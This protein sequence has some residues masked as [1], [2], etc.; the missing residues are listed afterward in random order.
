MTR[1]AARLALLF[2]LLGLGSSGAASYIHYQLLTVPAYESVCDVSA[3]VNCTDVYSSRYG[4]FG[5]VSVAVLGA[6]WFGLA[7]LLSVAALRGGGKLRQSV[8]EYLFAGSTIG[9]A[10]VLYLG[11]ASFVV[12]K[13]VCPFC[14]I[15]YVAVAGLFLVSGRYSS[16]SLLAV[17]RQLATDLRQLVA[18]PAALGLAALFVAGSAGALVLFP[19]QPSEGLAGGRGDTGGRTAATSG[20]DSS[21]PDGFEEWFAQLPRVSLNE[22]LEG[23]DV[24]VV[25]FNDY[26]CPPCR[27]T[28]YS[29]Q[30]VFQNLN[31]RYPG[32]V[33]Y[34][35]RDFPL[36]MECNAIVTRD[37]HVSGCEA[38][39]AVRLARER[40]RASEMEAWL[41]ENQPSL[42]PELVARG[43]RD[44]GGAVD[45]QDRYEATLSDV[46]ADIQRGIDIGV[47]STPTFVINNVMLAGGVPPPVLELI[48]ERELERA[49]AGAP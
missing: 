3:T 15:T 21:V 35:T 46:R 2:A 1:T 38:A 16:M 37:F 36:D 41:F 11:Y 33:K 49:A 24:V 47:R 39:V 17:P 25:K 32:R 42:T 30:P 5:G 27:Q 8:T 43:A 44:V 7:T 10:V 40:G 34:V 31:A 9:L 19:R 12:L 48:I 29:Y 13:L 28:Y 18:T 14:V 6:I 26:Q 45:Y 4:A 23:A 20:T 22:P